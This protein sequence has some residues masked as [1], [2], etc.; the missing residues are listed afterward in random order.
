[1]NT[2]LGS[3]MVVFMGFPTL[4]GNQKHEIKEVC[5]IVRRSPLPRSTPSSPDSCTPF[6]NAERSSHHRLCCISVVD[7]TESG[8]SQG[9]EQR[10][11]RCKYSW[12]VFGTPVIIAGRKMLTPTAGPS[13]HRSLGFWPLRP[14]CTGVWRAT[15]VE[16]CASAPMADGEEQEMPH[17]AR[18]FQAAREGRVQFH[19]HHAMFLQGQF[20]GAGSHAQHAEA[21]IVS[22]LLV[23]KASTTACSSSLGDIPGT[24]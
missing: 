7:G 8:R 14:G 13:L 3:S 24:N 4:H 11:D 23:R 20:G 16:A 10:D 6:L 9:L 22:T 12:R 2:V 19:I 1:M 15:S 17:L 18:C 5:V 21:D